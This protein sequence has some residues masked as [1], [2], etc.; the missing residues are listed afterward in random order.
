MAPSTPESRRQHLRWRQATIYS[1]LVGGLIVVAAWAI[2]MWTGQL[3][4]MFN[5]DFKYKPTESP[6]AQMA[7]CPVGAGATYPAV[8]A[9]TVKVL[10]GTNKDGLAGN[11]AQ[12]LAAQG[13][14]GPATGNAL[15]YEG[16]ARLV[17]G[18][19]GVNQ[20]YTLLEFFPEGTII[21]IDRR[22]G[23]LV[24]AILGSEFVSLR[25]PEEIGFDPAATIE[26]LPSCRQLDE[27]LSQGAEGD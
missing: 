25:A 16:V 2:G 17:A 7:P 6:Q 22:E 18:G 24:D 21:T 12:A 4:P 27:I 13:F 5:D 1:L 8:T 10:N 20:A 23:T 3:Q 15:P 11:T 9:V 14:P 19:E 26:P